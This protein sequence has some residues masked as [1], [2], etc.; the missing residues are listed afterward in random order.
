MV[1]PDLSG[2]DTYLA[3]REINP[4]IKSILSSGYS[5][6]HPAQESLNEGVV[7]LIQKPF[8]MNELSEKVAEALHQSA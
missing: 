6:D 2:R 1:M 5:I 4:K 3:M 8:N 7:S